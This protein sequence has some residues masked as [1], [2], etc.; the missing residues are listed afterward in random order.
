VIGTPDPVA[1][2]IVKAF[3]WLKPGH[4]PTRALRLELIGFGRKRLGAAL[5]DI[6]LDLQPASRPQPR[7]GSHPAS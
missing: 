2:E 7:G 3:V 5:V 6:G 1:G 4:D